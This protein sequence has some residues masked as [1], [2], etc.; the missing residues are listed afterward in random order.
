MFSPI[1]KLCHNPSFHHV[2]S[3]FGLSSSQIAFNVF[4]SQLIHQFQT[5]CNVPLV[6]KDDYVNEEELDKLLS[7]AYLS[8]P[9]FFI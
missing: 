7:S 5:N 1:V 3:L 4:Y 9:L 2:A 8:T 6:I